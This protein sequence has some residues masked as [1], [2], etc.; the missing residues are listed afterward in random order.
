MVIARSPGHRGAGGG[1][2]RVYRRAVAPSTDPAD[3]RAPIGFAHRG[4]SALAPENT[5]EAFQLA[6][7]LGASGLE[8][9]VHVSQDGVAILVH[10]PRFALDGAWWTV[11][12]LP[13]DALESLAKPRLASLYAQVGT[14][15]PLSLD[16]NDADPVEAAGAVVAAAKE[17]GS[18]AIG[19]LLLCHG[20]RRVLERVGARFGDVALVHST[21]RRYFGSPGD[22]ARRLADLGIGVVNLHW[23]DWGPDREAAAA[24]EAVH[25]ARLRAFAWDT[26]TAAIVT[27][28]AA[29]GV[30]GVYADDPRV[31]VAARSGPGA[32]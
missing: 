30:D 26:Q 12:D 9:D 25:L 24:I 4:A 19:G 27:R 17:A 31:L 16:L 28:M 5:L 29:L 32:R 2:S 7:E 20:D 1:P 21:S 13:A 18:A 14:A 22:H 23:K 11:R 6:L 8:C 15:L 10:D 3:P